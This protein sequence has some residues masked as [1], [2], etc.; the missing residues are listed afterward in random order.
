MILVDFRAVDTLGEIVVVAI[1]ALAAATLLGAGQEPDDK[2]KGM[3]EF[4]SVLIRQGMRPLAAVLLLVSLVVLWR[5]HNLPGGGFIGGLVAAT[6]FTLMIVTYGRGIQRGLN[7]ITPPTVIAVGLACAIGA[8]FFGLYHGQDYMQSY[9]TEVFGVK[10]GTPLLFDVGV[11]LTV[12]GS[13]MHMLR[14][15]IGRAA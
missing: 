10:L 3:P 4:G 8:G 1:A 7:R 14:N 15:L 12:F 6:G 2:P 9:W 5:G 11:F 13:V